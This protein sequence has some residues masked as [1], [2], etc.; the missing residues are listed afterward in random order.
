M[1]L[2]PTQE[3]IVNSFI[4][5]LQATIPELSTT[6]VSVV[7]EALI[8]PAASQIDFL[9]DL[10]KRISTLQDVFKASGT[11]LDTLAQTY[12]LSR[13]AGTNATGIVYLDLS[14]LLTRT[15]IIVNSGTQV[16]T[17]GGSAASFSIVG[18]YVFSSS[19]RAIFEANASS[20]RSQLDSVGL[21]SVRLV[22]PVTIQAL[23]TGSQGNVGGFTITSAN[24]P[25]V[26]NVLNVSPT[27]GGTDNESDS[28]LRTRIVNIFTGNSVGTAA[29]LLAAATTP[30]SIT[31]GFVVKYGDPLMTRD[32]SVYDDAGNLI[33]PGTGRAVDVYVQG[34]SLASTTQTYPFTLQ[35]TKNFLSFENAIFVGENTSDQFGFLPATAINSI[36]GDESAASFSQGITKEDEE[37]NILIEGNFALIKDVEADRYKIVE[38]LITKER[39]LATYLSPTST[40]YTIVETL[41]PSDFANSS[42][43]KD[44][45]LFLKNKVSITDESITKG[46]Y[47]GADNLIFQNVAS[48]DSIYQDLTISETIKV[49]NFTEVPGGISIFTKNSPIVSLD[50][51]TNTRLG[52]G[53]GGEILDAATGQIKLTG[54][55]PPRA[56]DYVVVSYVWRKFYREG[57]NYA[58]AGDLVDWLRFSDEKGRTN[59]ELLASEV[60][61]SQIEPSQQPAVPS[62]LEIQLSG[63]PDR[64]V[65]EL[66]IKGTTINEKSQQP[67]I[68][69]DTPYSFSITGTDKIGR[70]LKV[71]NISKGI[72]Y[73]LTNYKLKTNRFDQSA[74]IDGM[75]LGQHFSLDSN[76]NQK[77]LEVGD[78]ILLGRKQRTLAWSTESDFVNNIEDNLAPIYDPTITSFT[79]GGITLTNPTSNETTLTLSG[80]ITE[81][82]VLSG[83]VEVTDDLVI[84][85]GIVVDIEPNTI[86]KVRATNELASQIVYNQ[87]VLFDS[88][89]LQQDTIGA[90]DSYSNSYLPPSLDYDEYYY[91]YFRPSGFNSS[92]FTILNDQGQS[93]T[94]RF[95]SDIL[96]KEVVDGEIRF[97]L[98]GRAVGSSFN[99][100]LET[101]IDLL[102][103]T[104]AIKASLIGAR[105]GLES[106]SVWTAALVAGKSSYYVLLE[107]TPLITANT[108]NDFQL[109]STDDNSFTYS[110]FAYQSNLNALTVDE[111]I[112]IDGYGILTNPDDYRLN[113]QI[114]ERKRVAIIVEGTLRIIGASEQSSV[115][116]TSNSQDAKPGDWEG[117]LFSSK[118]HTNNPRTLFQSSL[119]FA[120]I[121]FANVGVKVQSSDVN[122]ESCVIKD[123]LVAGISVSSG[124]KSNLNYRT[125]EFVLTSPSDPF[126]KFSPTTRRGYASSDQVRIARYQIP[127]NMTTS[128]G[129]L[130]LIR[131]QLTSTSYVVDLKQ[132]IDLNL[133]LDNQS[134]DSIDTTIPADGYADFSLVQ[135]QDYFIEYDIYQGYSLVLLYTAGSIKAR[136]IYNLILDLA[137]KNKTGSISLDYFSALPNGLI[138]NNIISSAN[139]GIITGSLA[140]T[141]INKNT[142]D[143]VTLG[144]SG[145]QTIASVRNNLITNYSLAP[146]SFDGKS[147]VRMQRN[148]L[149]S[150]IGNEERSLADRD[151]LLQNISGIAT[152]LLVRTPAKFK[153]G[154]LIELDSEQMLVQGVND[155]QIMVVRGYNQTSQ[156]VHSSGTMIKLYQ[157]SQIFTVSGIEG[158]YCELLETDSEGRVLENSV[159]IQMLLLAPNTFKTNFPI[160][161]RADFHYKHRYGFR[162]STIV[163]ET[164]TKVFPKTQPGKGVNDLVNLLHEIPL[165]LVS[166]TPNNEN[167]SDNPFYQN[168]ASGDFSFSPIESLASKDNPAFGSLALP[169]SNHK[170]VGYL[171]VEL[172]RNLGVG[173]RKIAATFEPLIVESYAEVVVTGVDG[174]NSGV[175]IPIKEFR[176]EE[177]GGYFIIDDLLLPDGVEI[178]GNYRVDY[179]RG[180][181]LGSGITPYYLETTISYTLDAKSTVNFEIFEF[182]KDLVGGEVS[183]TTRVAA[184]VAE[185]TSQ[186]LSDSSSVSPVDLSSL[187]SSNQGRAIELNL[188]LKG[189]DFGF[190]GNSTT[191]F[192]ILQEFSLGILPNKDDQTYKILSLSLNQVQNETNILIDR[193]IT[194]SSFQKVGQ[195]SSLQLYVRKRADNFSESEEFILGEADGISVGDTF[196][197]GKTDLTTSKLDSSGADLIR[198]DYLNYEE[199]QA[200]SLWFVSDGSQ[201]TGQK[202]ATITDLTSKITRNQEEALPSTET[203]AIFEQNQPASGEQYFAS[204]SFEA[205][206]QDETLTIQHSYNEAIRRSAQEVE[207]RKSIFSDVL[208]KQVKVVE[209]RLGLTLELEPSAAATSVQSQVGQAIAELFTTT[210]ADLQTERRLDSSDIIRAT[211]TISGIENIIVTTLSRNLITGEVQ[212]PI[213][214]AKR[215]SARL[216]DGSPSISLVQSGRTVG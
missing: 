24:I 155:N 106:N 71:S 67:A 159:P 188:T 9:F 117:L 76:A 6:P 61:K 157:L 41:E 118:S 69:L 97:F 13:R 210:F 184:S 49:E 47:N 10:G 214:I 189:N 55:V 201:I 183:I 136:N 115:L 19:D 180:V 99:Y 141:S 40:K 52:V 29:G 79:A 161:R 126:I 68:K 39:K 211:G 203:I 37:G 154:M 53:I 174:L 1:I 35:N 112:L 197:R 130:P 156:V 100:E 7:R 95:D 153:V 166:Y 85:E 127:D 113:Y 108:Q 137:S 18:G 101:T 90:K 119:E 185:L 22:A 216:E 96:K 36:I 15:T 123:S 11:D 187:L 77:F 38:N 94:I 50:S 78:Q 44:R 206:L 16:K 208:V 139:T 27:S 110:R 177:D 190:S 3:D 193:P 132:G 125:S 83:V 167:F 162:N 12:G 51:I 2:T 198:V 164:L 73:N 131:E 158:D 48:L 102:E 124:P 146:I 194:T 105:S 140:T 80:F 163:N 92:T 145:S 165:T 103:L 31:G 147:L 191:I 170:Y 111:N 54:R 88:T 98:S 212:D 192:P 182:I 57:I 109:Q 63:I 72:D 122:I 75:L 33:T 4:A 196:V 21:T 46:F 58:L 176:F 8:N 30:S 151:L 5:N 135:N 74:K 120:R 43:S 65:V 186:P 213:I 169:A 160:N 152:M 64:E 138:Y 59:N 209:I 178:A 133:Y 82:S 70:L 143:G 199:N 91:V 148:C 179:V 42:F 168:Q 202:F 60:V 172:A 81:D 28:S 89:L 207:T 173:D 150:S 66:T 116:F 20:I 25:G 195:D 175:I 23:S 14:Q 129:L 17:R 144:I 149:Y 181:N 204:Y 142:I 34:T 87:R 104:S 93:L 215:E 205:P 86:I 171:D 134:F 26:N 45:V 128:L 32:G 121:R 56:G 107:K 200:E 84:P 114:E 62:N